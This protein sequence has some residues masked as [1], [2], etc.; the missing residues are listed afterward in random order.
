[1]VFGDDGTQQRVLRYR[2]HERQN[3]LCKYL[4]IP[5]RVARDKL[6]DPF[7]VIQSPSRPH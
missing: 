1:L 7:E 6:E 2:L 4:G 5:V 3:S